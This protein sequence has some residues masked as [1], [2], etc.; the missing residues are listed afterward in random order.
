MGLGIARR[1]AIVTGVSRGIGRAVAAQLCREGAS[2]P[3]C[4]RTADLLAETRRAVE[5]IGGGRLTVEADPADPA[6][7]ARV[8][9]PRWR[10][11]GGWISW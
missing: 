11:G 8:A 7:A 1:A 9:G 5:A 2:V 6:A 3:I 4:T 10:N